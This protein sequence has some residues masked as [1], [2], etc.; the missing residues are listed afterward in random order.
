MYRLGRGERVDNNEPLSSITLTS[1][2]QSIGIQVL[3][4]CIEGQDR[5]SYSDI[6]C[7]RVG[8]HVMHGQ[9]PAE[10]TL[11]RIPGQHVAKVLGTLR[12]IRSVKATSI[13]Y[14]IPQPRHIRQR[15]VY[16]PSGFKST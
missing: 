1:T 2:T 13:S 15:R 3:K 6:L 8:S 12:K 4:N 5:R 16:N 7:H 9:T 14:A 10:T 11:S